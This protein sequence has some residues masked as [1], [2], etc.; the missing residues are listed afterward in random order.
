VNTATTFS[1][2]LITRVKK[3]AYEILPAAGMI[4]DTVNKV[5]SFIQLY[6]N[7]NWKVM[8]E[9]QLDDVL[10]FFDSR[11][12][13]QL[14]AYIENALTPKP[15]V[16]F[17]ESI[18]LSLVARG[19]EVVPCY[20]RDKQVH[21][22]LVP[23]PLTMKSKDPA[24]IREWGHA[25]PFAN[26]CVYA[27]QHE[28]GLLFLDK[29]G[30]ISLVE[31]Y[32][33]ETG[34]MFPRTLLVQSSIADNGVPKGHW[35]FL[36][37]PRT[38]A[39][40]GN[41]SENK[42]GGLFSLR[43]KN[44]YVTSIGSIHPKTG[45]PYTVADDA[46]VIPM[47]D[48]FLD[49][50]LAQVKEEPKTREEVLQQG[51]LTK[52]TRYP[53]LI[54]YIG[55]LW[56]A[57]TPREQV[58][59]AGIAWAREWF[60]LPEGAFNEALVKGEIEHFL[61]H[62]YEQG[63]PTP[64]LN[65]NQKPDANS[66]AARLVTQQTNLLNLTG[67]PRA[68]DPWEYALKPLYGLQFSGWFPLGRV[69]LVSGSSG[70]MKTTFLT[71]ALVAGRDGEVF[72]GHE[73][74]NLPFLFLFADRGKYD[75]EE[76]FKRMNLVGKVPFRSI[77]GIPRNTAAQVI[78][79]AA[80][81]GEYK[82]LVID[83]G[84]LLVPDNNDGSS[85]GDF[86]LAV[87][88][89]AEHYGVGII[90]T[91]GA[92]KLS[93]QAL[94]QGAERRS[95]TKGSEVWGRTGGSVFTLN[96]E[97]DGTQDTRRLVV[98]HRNAASE[99]FLLQVRNGQLV[100]VDEARLIEESQSKT[101]LN[102]VLGREHFTLAEAKRHFKWSGASATEKLTALV[103]AGIVKNH[104]RKGAKGADKRATWFEVPS[105]IDA[106]KRAAVECEKARAANT[107]NLEK[108]EEKTE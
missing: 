91:T 8:T 2:E 49:W 22:R 50:L 102:W 99:R 15:E 56:S 21:G 53:S 17:F 32:E 73:P 105:A 33:R 31:K 65:L 14:V 76:T 74:G 57:G 3:Y 40:D 20:P 86:T 36:Q 30:A 10:S 4:G 42:T 46:P 77:N 78:G 34:K 52:G 7:A 63:Q 71:Q 24:K 106:L 5:D 61:D 59:E 68:F 104:K 55:K 48:D 96:S 44:Y 45:L 95:I 103:T 39:L 93:P 87:Q 18:A 70:A 19:F 54:S 107:V 60:D 90:V 28:G 67:E 101:I 11:E 75:C 92:G 79:D 72:L 58:I 29:D 97:H 94:K 41:I 16:T 83:G 6:A 1:P 43:V 84:D 23:S 35:Y 27:E 37:T 64:D 26:V 51:R 100:A 13:A 88:R 62:G 82:I 81:N 98:Q 69:T 66:P 47:P 25:E 38:V 108:T 80:A 85:V 9:E 12:P 89:I